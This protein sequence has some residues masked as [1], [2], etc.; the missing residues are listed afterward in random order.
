MVC[1]NNSP[2][3]RPHSLGG[4]NKA[5]AKADGYTVALEWDRAF[6]LVQNDI[7]AYN[8]YYSTIRED[9]FTEGVKFV[10][11]ED[12]YLNT[13]IFGL[14]PG[15][16]YYFAVRATEFS[17]GDVNLSS[18]PDS[19]QP[20]LKVYPETILLSDISDTDLSIPVA[21]IND[22]PAYGTILIGTEIIKYSNKDI[23][24]SAL[25]V[26]DISGRGYLD[27]NQRFHNTDGYDGVEYQNPL[28]KFWSG[29]D[30]GNSVVAQETPKFAYPY[31]ARTDADGYKTVNADL[32]T[33]DLSG[34]D[35]SQQ[36]FTPYDFSGWRRTDP[37]S[38][39]RG[40]CIGT[41]YGGEQ[42]CADG[43]NGVGRQIRGVPL[44]EEN[45]RRQETLLEI[46]GE[47]VVLVRRVWTGIRC[48]C[49]T[50]TKEYVSHRCPNCLGTGFVVGY[51]QFYNPRRSDGRILVRFGPTEDDLKFMDAGLE[52]TLIPDCWTLVV[53]AVKDRDFIIRFNE[54]GTEEF[55]YEILH[56][57]RNKLIESLSG[58]QKFSAQ[59]VRK[60]DPIYEF[61]SVYSTATMPE[62]INTTLGYVPGPGG[63]LPHTHEVVISEGIVSLTQINQ[64]TGLS[65]GHN[66]PIVD[67][68][69][70]TVLGHSHQIIL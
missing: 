23:P 12:G 14:T 9:V 60:T 58:G 33:T 63:I 68:Q 42:F 20:Y 65:K 59:R 40:D 34:S 36:D 13:C 10:S 1:T 26:S 21:D 56:V 32:L 51:D 8:I 11:V 4:I 22:F 18:L 16:T 2:V 41:Y 37:L 3:Y 69:V 15:D 38:L 19:D 7:L 44:Q 50:P 39:L 61:R 30:D 35:A 62:T 70:M 57:T 48:S 43:Y 66:H 67:G 29:F 54:D 45:S 25:I 31:Y 6:A 64:T 24:G 53:P 27:T 52:S 17:Q 46:T 47:P 49:Y 5:I 55:R 28:V